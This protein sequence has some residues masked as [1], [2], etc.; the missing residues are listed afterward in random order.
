MKLNAIKVAAEDKKKKAIEAA[1]MSPDSVDTAVSNQSAK[2]SSIA[3]AMR[4]DF[5]LGLTKKSLL[6]KTETRFV[7]ENSFRSAYAYATTVLSTHFIS[8]P[9]PREGYPYYNESKLSKEALDTMSTAAEACGADHIYPVN[10]NLVLSTDDTTVFAFSGTSEDGNDWEWKFLSPSESGG[11]LSDFDVGSDAENSGGLRLR[12]TFTFT[13]SGL[14]APPYVCV[15]G[16]T[17]Q[18]LP[19]DACPDGILV[20]EVPGLC[21]GGSNDVFAEGSGWLVFLR[22]DPSQGGDNEE[23]M[24]IANKK[25]VHYHTD[26]LLPFIRKVR[27]KLGWKPGQDVPDRLKAVSWFDGE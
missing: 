24:S 6:T 23:A 3:A 13:G 26:V 9:V 14:M 5:T 20:K 25:F 12:L 4:A 1:G 22:A 19:V 18:E 15:S 27:E 16:L 10:P 11:H 7:A 2:I 17:D 21:K 8:G